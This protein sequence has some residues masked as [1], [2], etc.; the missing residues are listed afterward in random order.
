MDDRKQ[1]GAKGE[2]I[3]KYYLIKKGLNLLDQ[4]FYT[5]E[6]ELDLVMYDA[7]REEYVLVE[8]KTRRSNAFGPGESAVTQQKIQKMYQAAQKYFE[9]KLGITDL[10]KLRVR[11]DVMVVEFTETGVW[12]RW[13]HR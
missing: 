9:R 10:D 3:A 2:E 8:V 5:R 1:I 7:V 12:C 6:G 13:T 4:N 11:V